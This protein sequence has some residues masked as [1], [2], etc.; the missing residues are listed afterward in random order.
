M[1]RQRAYDPSPWIKGCPDCGCPEPALKCSI[2]ARG[3]FWWIECGTCK[4]RGRE[5]ESV[6][7]VV[8][9]WNGQKETEDGCV[10]IRGMQ[11]PKTCGICRLKALLWGARGHLR[12]YCYPADREIVRDKKA[13]AV[14]DAF[15]K[16]PEWCPLM[17]CSDLPGE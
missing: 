2:S 11:M 3:L 17:K 7:K 8:S 13:E 1:N 6:S 15:S 12:A 5:D 4:K 10:I 16:R 14:E 9:E